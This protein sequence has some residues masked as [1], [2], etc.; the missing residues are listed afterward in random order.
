MLIFNVE[1]ALAD[2]IAS[3]EAEE[4]EA[5]LSSMD[6]QRQHHVPDMDQTDTSY[7]DM[8]RSMNQQSLA[9]SDTPY[10]SD[11]EEYDHL[12][13]DVIREEERQSSM[14]QAPSGDIDM[15]MS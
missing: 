11:D 2:E 6:E 1:E 7:L 8:A 13:M 10:G 12:F 5:L 14:Q 15:D 4:M 9:S 3:K